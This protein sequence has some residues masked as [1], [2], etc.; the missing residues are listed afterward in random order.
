M[1]V[2]IKSDNVGAYFVDPNGLVWQ[3]KEFHQNPT[4]KL[5]LV[6]NGFSENREVADSFFDDK[7]LLI[8]K[9]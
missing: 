2:E 1:N 4:A 7:T 5:I 3:L 9:E 8:Q 6:E